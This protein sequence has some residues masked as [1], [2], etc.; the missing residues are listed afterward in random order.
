MKMLWVGD[1]GAATGFARLTHAVCDAAHAE[2]WAVTVLGISY[3]GD[4]HTRPY[5]IYPAAR[6][7]REDP[8]GCDRIKAIAEDFEPD[9]IVIV[10]DPWNIPPYLEQ[11]PD[12]I[13]VIGALCIDGKNCRGRGLNGLRAAVFTTEFAL[14]EARAGGYT[15]RGLV[16]PYGVDT[17]FF[18]PPKDRQ[19]VR[20]E[21]GLPVIFGDDFIVGTVARNHPR[22]RLDLTVRY[23]AKWIE[24]SG[25]D[26]ARLFVH[27]TPTSTPGFDVMQLAE[28][29]G[30]AG[31]GRVMVTRNFDGTQGVPPDKLRAMIASMD[32]YL[33]TTQGE[34]WGLPI[35]EAMACGVPVIAPAWA[36]LGE[37][38]APAARLV[39]CTTVAHTP[40]MINVM[41]GV[42]DEA[43]T[44]A[45]LDELYHDAEQRR[46]MAA[47]G[48]ALVSEPR[49][50]WSSV[51]HE[52][53]SAIEEAVDTKLGGARRDAAE[54]CDDPRRRAPLAAIGQE[55]IGG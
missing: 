17:E 31:T 36:A 5:P 13:P 16:I 11:I 15:G 47:R 44:I 35:A 19:S 46:D 38:A 4:P 27:A 40:S 50:R 21:A 45:A 6:T 9:A 20:L 54:G 49:F 32:L 29:Y 2:G 34:G 55:A 39:D 1:A 24:D 28:C 43:A 53:L 30:L 14:Q 37:W 26:N 7:P 42:P 8:H 22:K 10:N 52:F 25:I 33:T 48:L 3:R 12:E 23:F 41:G 51:A 18:R